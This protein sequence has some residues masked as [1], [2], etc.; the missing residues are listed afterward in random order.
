MSKPSP[1]NQ[2]NP[3][4]SVEDQ[5]MHLESLHLTI[6]DQ[7]RA[8]IVI[9]RLG[10]HYFKDFADFYLHADGTFPSGTQF[11][12]IERV[13]EFDEELRDHILKGSRVI[14]LWL[15]QTMTD[16]M[17]NKHGGALWYA[18]TEIITSLRTIEKAIND[19]KSSSDESVRRY[20]NQTT[21]THPPSWRLARGTSFG[22]WA[23]FYT[24]IPDQDANSIA[25]LVGLRRADLS[26]YISQISNLRNCAAHHSKVWNST[27][28]GMTRQ[29]RKM[30]P[31]LKWLRDRGV[32]N[33]DPEG[34][35]IAPRLYGIH[36][37]LKV[38]APSS[39]WTDNLKQIVNCSPRQVLM[40]FSDRWEQGR[41]WDTYRERAQREERRRQKNLG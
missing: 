3:I 36:R 1:I 40:G 12:D 26:N 14:E 37:L 6:P 27:F 4:L 24:K 18:N 35:R 30:S 10:L 17:S 2:G 8:A 38:I 32:K 11:S 5:L 39:N 16:Y 7:Q 34:E 28:D 23:A 9:S 20:I 15:K 31:E 19:F 33:G 13:M 22:T 25:S 21:E 29:Q 41:E